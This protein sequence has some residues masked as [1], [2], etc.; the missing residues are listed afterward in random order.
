MTSFADHF[1]GE[2]NN[3]FFVLYHNMK[4]GQTA[5]KE[6]IDF[7]RE[8]CKVEESYSTLLNKLAR[9]AA[10]SAQVG[11]FAPF[12]TVLKTLAEKL[13]TLHTQLLHS[14]TDLIKDVARYN[15]DQHKRHKNMKETESGTQEIV[16]SIQQTTTS[17]HKAKE[18]YHTRCLERERLKRENASQKDME[19][20]EIKC[21]KASDDYKNLVDK[22]A[23]VRNE[24][25][26]KMLGSCKHFQELQEEHICQMKDFIDTYARAWESEHALI[27]QVHKEFKASCD[28]L[29]VQKLLE[30]FIAS[31]KTGTEKPG[32]IEFVEP[33]LSSLQA[34]RPMSPE[35]NDKR[36]SFSEKRGQ[37]STSA[38]KA[39]RT[40]SS[41]SPSPVLSDQPGPLSRSVKLRVSR[42][43]FLK[44]KK[45]KKKKKKEDKADTESVDTQEG[46][47]PEIDDEG[48]QIRPDDPMENN[49]DKTSWYSS[50]SDTDSDDD[51]KKK[52][53]VEIRPLSPNGAPPVTSNVKD[54][55]ASV[56]ALRLSPVAKKRSQTPTDKKMKRSQS[57][58]DT[59][60][61][62]K[63]AGL[64]LLNLDFFASSSASTPTGGGY[65]LPS[66]LSPMADTRLH[67]SALS[68]ASTT[69]NNITK[70]KPAPKRVNISGLF[71]SSSG[72]DGVAIN[73]LP[74]PS[75][76]I[77]SS[78]GGTGISLQAAAIPRPSSRNKGIIPQIPSRSSG[79]NS[80]A[81]IMGRS[82]S[83][84]FS[85]TSMLIGSSR[86]PS[87][88]TIGKSDTVPLAIAFTENIGAYFKGTDATQCMVKVI[89]NVMMSFPAGVVKVFTENPAPAVLSFQIK[90]SSRL[91]NIILNKQLI[92]EESHNVAED[93]IIYTFNMSALTDHLRSQG[94]ENKSASYFNIDILKYQGKPQPGV[95]SCP[96]P[97]VVYWKCEDKHTDFRLDYKYNPK[98]MSSPCALK[99]ITA[100]VVVN[101]GVESM[102]SIP[103]GN[104]NEEN[105]RAT[106]KL[107]D[108]AE[109]SEEGSAGS[110]RAKFNL[111]SGPSK[112][113]TTAMTF[114]SE[115]ASLTGIDFELVGTGYR[116]SLSKKRFAAGK[117]VADPDLNQSSV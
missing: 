46:V 7:L 50:D 2:K 75:S 23:T 81:S 105:Q 32:P 9:T 109:L 77:T 52:I 15:D 78:P 60:D 73:P 106:W 74:S 80:P 96:L 115:G 112:P 31:K 28:E 8:S 70:L 57:E 61:S 55:K 51:N 64:D 39:Q 45:E 3:G 66:P 56:E 88:L 44:K 101:G 108:L 20:A 40:Y 34:P 53:K 58:S 99:N 86:G 12:W 37:D 98:S 83:M 114:I 102:Q 27:G 84:T 93:C 63:P 29:S 65:N 111:K 95:E 113:S 41:G 36:E 89:G 87:P 49:G 85:T 92:V 1:W 10:T 103:S 91:N 48:Y 19:K 43:W 5:S 13:A 38:S 76:H 18:L 117:Y 6:F 42:T 47:T 21:K 30:N 94:E 104:W 69:P 35:P 54:I 25:E 90:N 72:S 17:L 116:I 100:T 22:Y 79:R 71:N 97:L 59:L 62:L 14:W 11:T 33:D 67:N 16:H 110:I 4:H 82:D 24:F 107:N 68:S 26:T